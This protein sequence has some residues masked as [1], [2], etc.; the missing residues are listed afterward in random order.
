MLRLSSSAGGETTHFFC[1][2]AE[3]LALAVP[4]TFLAR[5]LISFLALRPF[6]GLTMIFSCFIIEI[7]L[8]KENATYLL[9]RLLAVVL[10]LHIET[11]I[12]ECK[13][14]R[15]AATENGLATEDCDAVF[16]NLEGL[17][18]FG[19][20]SC[21]ADGALF[22]MDHLNLLRIVSTES[23]LTHC[24]RQRRGLRRN[25]RT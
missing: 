11:V 9:Q 13:T 20:D 21:L 18:E 19:R 25:L 2:P 8:G 1:L 10:L 7:N 17:C 15:S 14:R 12:D 16:L 24:L 22:G 6:L 23:L 3:T 5:P 4:A